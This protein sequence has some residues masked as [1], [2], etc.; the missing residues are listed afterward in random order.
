MARRG[1]I[2]GERRGGYGV[3]GW[4]FKSPERK[5]GI[6]GHEE[7]SSYRTS[8]SASGSVSVPSDRGANALAWT[9]YSDAYS[10]SALRRS[11]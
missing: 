4:L 7:S 3:V 10:P 2:E 11:S 8:I 1:W 9:L 6:T 5:K